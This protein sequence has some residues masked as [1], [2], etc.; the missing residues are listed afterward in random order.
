MPSA[1]PFFLMTGNDT[2]ID[3]S[4]LYEAVERKFNEECDRL[5]ISRVVEIDGETVL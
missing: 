2:I 4:D 5:G 1:P 3:E